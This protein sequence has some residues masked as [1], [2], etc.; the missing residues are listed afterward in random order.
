MKTIKSVVTAAVPLQIS[1][2]LNEI[3]DHSSIE[4]PRN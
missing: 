1:I 4:T 3:I 2:T